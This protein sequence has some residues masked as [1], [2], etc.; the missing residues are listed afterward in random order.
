MVTVPGASLSR[1]AV[2]PIFRISLS[3]VDTSCK[4]GTFSNVT[5]SAV[6]N[7]AHS[8]GN[9]AFL[10]PEMMTVPFSDLP[11]LISNLSMIWF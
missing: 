11:P 5:V 2:T 7:A 3:M 6:N 8:S 9:A 4:P 10:A 1:S